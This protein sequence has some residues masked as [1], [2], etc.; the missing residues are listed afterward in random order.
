MRILLALILFASVAHAAPA[1]NGDLELARRLENAFVKVAEQASESVVVIT[2]T[3]KTATSPGEEEDGPMPFEFFFRR[4]GAPS[5]RE[6]QA[7]G[8]ILR[9][10]GYI[11]TNHHVIDGADELKVRLKDGR[12][13]VATV[14]GSDVRTDV[15]VIRVATNEL[16]AA[17]LGDS[18]QV[19]PG[20]WA[21]AIGAPFEYDYSFTVGFVSAKGRSIQPRDGN[22][23]EDFL[24]TD[25]SINPGN[26][27]G[28]LCDI[29]G[30]V[31]G[32]NTLIRGLNTGIGFAI[33]INLAKQVA[34]QLIEHGKVTRP[35]LGIQ[36]EPL[37]A[38]KESSE[39]F[40]DIPDGIVVRAIYPN[41]PAASSDLQPADVIVAVD[42]VSV[43]QPR[44]LQ[45]AVLAKGVGQK[46]NLTVVRDGKRLNLSVSTGEQPEQMPGES[47]STP[48]QPKAE[49]ALGLTVQTLTKDIADRLQLAE[50][51]GVVVTEVAEDSP[52][53]AKD[54][55]PGDVIAE[56][57][58]QPVRNT[59]EFRAALRKADMNKGVLLLVR[60]AGA[61]TFVVL[62]ETKP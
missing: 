13:L 4:Y 24:Q 45:R 34:N 55:R 15:A 50:T 46:L 12:V 51:E 7:S 22:A 35:W 6:A 37:T 53:Q 39:L 28:P 16:S 44:D 20:Q 19:K 49:T 14:I 8:I 31:I 43:Q 10:D 41:T 59:E 57:N 30:R 61:S 54:M 17:A 58:R 62:K 23:Y 38:N 2:S 32:M 11:L 33:P 47:R 40:K 18:D 36:I 1:A 3:R 9:R 60:R 27:G 29:E 25:A 5:P 42:G 56:V 21:I 48:A 26:S 52:S